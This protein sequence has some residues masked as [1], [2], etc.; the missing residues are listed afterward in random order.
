MALAAVGQKYL[1]TKDV[2]PPGGGIALQSSDNTMYSL[3]PFI[4]LFGKLF[5]R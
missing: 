4:I 5:I 1:W 3:I 2:V